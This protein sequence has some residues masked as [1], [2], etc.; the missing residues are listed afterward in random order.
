MDDLQARELVARVDSLLEQVDGFAD[1]AAREKTTELVGVLLDLYGEGLARLVARAPDPD[2]LQDDELVSHLLLL[3]GIHPVPLDT[4]VRTALEEV[5]P[6]LDS[7]G[8]NVELVGVDGG[9]V[10]LRM[11]GSCSGCPSSAVTLK[12]A[13]EDAIRKHAPDVGEIEAEDA[14]PEGLAMAPTGG[15]ALIELTPLGPAVNGNSETWTLA[16]SLPQLRAG[17]SVLK[18]IA[19]EPV[20]FLRVD[21]TCY[22][23]RPNCPGC[24]GSLEDGKLRAAELR[25][26]GCGLAYSVRLAG[27]CID[28]P[29]MSLVPVPL[30]EDEAGMVK[31]A[32]A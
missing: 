28:S 7:H 10:R 11:E 4:R 31:V 15:P 9:T 8:G 17:G 12:L 30:L 5:R 21:G 27:R 3:H 32:V 18:K 20:L 13:I 14:A 25:C 1:L 6:Y 24:G 16:G 2:A 19:G 23:Y 26:S 22:A 29:D